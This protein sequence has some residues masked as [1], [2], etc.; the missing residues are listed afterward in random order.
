MVLA[1]PNQTEEKTVR[2]VQSSKVRAMEDH[3][4]LQEDAVWADPG[5]VFDSVYT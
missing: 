1:T 5:M 2:T 3:R 4:S